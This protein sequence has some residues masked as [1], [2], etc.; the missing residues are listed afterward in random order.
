MAGQT[1][2]P[3]SQ[4][5]ST[6]VPD[7]IERY[8]VRRDAWIAQADELARLRD[9][10]RGSAEREAMEIVTAARRDVRKVIMEARRELLVL[11][12]QVQAALGEAAPKTDPTTLLNKAG[13][14]PDLEAHSL[15]PSASGSPFVPEDA[16]NEILSEV[17]EDMSAL[18]ADAKA[19]PL[20][21]LPQVRQIAAPLPSVAPPPPVAPQVQAAPEPEPT[22]V[23]P[24]LAT[25]R[26]EMPVFTPASF[27]TPLQRPST[28]PANTSSLTEF[29]PAVETSELSD[30]RELIDRPPLSESASAVLLSSQ[31]PSDAVPVQSGR[32]IGT[33]VAAF[34]GI[35]IVVVGVTIW[36]LSSGGS[37]ADAPAVVADAAPSAPAMPTAPSPVADKAA[38]SASP[39][40]F[41]DS[42]R[43]SLVAEAV[44]DVWV[45]TTVDGRSDGGQTLSAGQVIDVY[46]EKTISVRAGDGGALVFSLNNGQKQPLGRS[47]QPVTRDFDTQ[48]PESP[49]P[50][51]PAPPPAKPLTPPPANAR[52]APPIAS[53]TPA[54]APPIPT[55]T[56]RPAPPMPTTTPSGSANIAQAPPMP[57]PV[58]P[59]VAPAVAPAPS[60]QVANNTQPAVPPGVIN[61]L[62]APANSSAPVAVSPANVVVAIA[63]QWL[64][65]Y[66]RQDRAAMAALSTENLLLA[67]E[68]RPEERFPPGLADVTRALDRVSVQIAADTAVLTAVMTEQSGSQPSPHVSPISQ[69]WVLGAGQ[70]KVRQARFVS[71]ARLNQVFR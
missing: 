65:A 69:V 36:W 50:A 21:A 52:T 51:A 45:R 23:T 68:R 57:N 47:G 9:E 1:D 63:R 27:S 37:G 53:A 59:P 17:Q 10:V 71:E 39:G 11:S 40:A 18:A 31:F 19:L 29:S 12:A 43:L 13:I 15:L 38:P 41:G 25:P 67:D 70:W 7:L 34:V 48:K 20:Q 54:P 16:V 55:P 42:G 6:A 62:S 28:P 30:I 24:R 60:N 64:D 49:V 3:Q 2:Q 26:T 32:R 35:G 56:P 4:S 8:R 61:Q 44:R 33:F 58:A 22:I 14:T 66:H 46:A 5:G